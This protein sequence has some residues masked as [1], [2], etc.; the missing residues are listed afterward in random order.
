MLLQLLQVRLPTTKLYCAAVPE[1]S[2]PAKAIEYAWSGDSRFLV[3]KDAVNLE[4]PRGP[5]ETNAGGPPRKS[6][7]DQAM[8]RDAREGGA[9]GGQLA[10]DSDRQ[11]V[12]PLDLVSTE[13]KPGPGPAT[14]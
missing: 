11:T 4:H 10:M 6:S 8:S 7:T 9:K 14:K 5:L 1:L 12:D 2:R 3:A 13:S